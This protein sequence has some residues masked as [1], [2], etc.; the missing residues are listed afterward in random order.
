MTIK[1]YQYLNGRL[2]TE[3]DL[4]SDP[5]SSVNSSYIPDII[6]RQT[7]IKTA[8]IGLDEIRSGS[9][10][11]MEALTILRKDGCRIVVM[12]VENEQDLLNIADAINKCFQK[13]LPCG[14][15]GLFSRMFARERSETRSLKSVVHKNE[16]PFVVI[17]GSP[18]EVSKQPIIFSK[19]YG[20]EVIKLELME[21]LGGLPALLQEAGRVGSL[22][23][24]YLSEGKNVVVDGAGEG[25]KELKNSYNDDPGRLQRDSGLIREVLSSIALQIAGNDDIRR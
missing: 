15:A 3:S 25:K 21:T 16:K 11:I 8:V 14:S 13:V 12:D 2:L 6:G 1:G 17:S 7:S 23:V 4:A 24:K 20:V 19:A 5:F 9:D 18:A 22:A 10:S